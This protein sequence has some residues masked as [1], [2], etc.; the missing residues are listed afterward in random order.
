MTDTSEGLVVENATVAFSHRGRH[1]RALD[2]VSLHAPAGRT[3]GVVGESGS[4]KSTLA[5][6]LVGV[7][8]LNTGTV[9]FSGMPVLARS[10][11]PH[12]REIARRVQLIPQ[13]AYSSLDPR[14]TIG[15]TIAE[16]ID[17][18]GGSARRHRGAIDAALEEVQLDPSTAFR[19]PQTLSGGQRQRVAIAR[20]LVVRPELVIADEITSALDVSVQAGILKLLERIQA[21]HDLTMLFISHNLAVVSQVCDDIV[22]M[23]RGRIVER[24]DSE[25]IFSAPQHPY[26]QRLVASIPGSPGFSLL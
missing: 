21:S 8:R 4:G 13:D 10:R 5:K 3:L 25:R 14:R 12:R 24:A 7:Q 1:F 22:V 19:L 18:V 6:A 16:A 9:T 2:D 15:E 17:P 20:A 26:T 11:G 23:Q